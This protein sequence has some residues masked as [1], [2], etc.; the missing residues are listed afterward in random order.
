MTVIN[1]IA[2]VLWILCLLCDL[3]QEKHKYSMQLIMAHTCLVMYTAAAVI[4]GSSN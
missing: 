2:L 4:N 3:L 1:T